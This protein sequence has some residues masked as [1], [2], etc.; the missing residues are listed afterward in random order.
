MLEEA[1]AQLS[2][3]LLSRYEAL[4]RRETAES[5]ELETLHAE[6]VPYALRDQFLPRPILAYMGYH[7]TSAKVAFDDV[8]SIGDA[9]FIPQLVRDFLAIHDDIVD[10]DLEKF[11]EPPL[12][13]AYSYR[14]GKQAG[15][16]GITKQGKDLALFYGDFLLGMIFRIVA[17]I[18]P[19]AASVRMTKLLADTLYVNQ[20]GQLKELLLEEEPLTKASLEDV[21]DVHKKKAAYYCYSLPFEVGVVAAGHDDALARSVGAVLLEL[22]TASQIIDDVTGALPGVLDHDKDTLGEIV[23]LRRTVPLVLLAQQDRLAPD[24][25]NLLWYE[26]PLDQAEALRVREALWA[27]EVPRQSVALVEEYA[28]KVRLQLDGLAIEGPTREYLSDLVD[29]R[30]MG[31]VE[32][33]REAAK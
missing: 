19:S 32:K 5:P 8:D 22:G 18:E 11:G 9:L 26:Q 21:L 30:L 27:S 31:N 2:P 29:R 7:A 16:V 3:T 6:Y 15:E 4:L 13:V 14:S 25:R 23:N 17:R 28:G 24:I 20:R 12:P 1:F 33:L 10:E